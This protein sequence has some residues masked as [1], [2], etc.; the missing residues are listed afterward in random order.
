MST[1]KITWSYNGME[2]TY[3]L[4]EHNGRYNLENVVDGHLLVDYGWDS[5]E[6][7]ENGLNVI[8]K[9]SK[10]SKEESKE[11]TT[12]ETKLNE[13]FNDKYI[14]KSNDI[15]NLLNNKLIEV[16]YKKAKGFYYFNVEDDNNPYVLIAKK[17][18]NGYWRILHSR[19]SW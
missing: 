13:L 9:I 10:W 7:L 15:E 11:V 18:A 8:D 6:A 3:K 12:F 19:S 5:I 2:S 17:Q 4:V 14:I 1:Y 16:I